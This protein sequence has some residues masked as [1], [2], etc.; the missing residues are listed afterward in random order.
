VY[1]IG[2]ADDC[3]RERQAA[4]DER[5]ANAKRWFVT[6]LE[7]YIHGGVCLAL[8]WEHRGFPD[9]RW[10]VSRLGYVVVDREALGE[11]GKPADDERCFEIA[12]GLVED[13]N[14]YLEGRVFGFTV[15]HTFSGAQESCGGFY[16]SRWDG[17]TDCLP[18]ARSV[19]EALDAHWRRKQA[20]EQAADNLPGPVPHGGGDV[21]S[22]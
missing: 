15:K 1:K 20:E 13:W 12:K 9:R 19:A 11:A 17:R 4:W 18:E 21:D 16:D 14:T 2:Y 3:L 22:E 6:P 7:A 8:V 10:D 5:V